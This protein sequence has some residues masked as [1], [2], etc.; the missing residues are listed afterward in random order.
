MHFKEN[1]AP[2][3]HGYLFKILPKNLEKL[4]P[5]PQEFDLSLLS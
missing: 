5:K 2:R 3:D 1:G 4:F